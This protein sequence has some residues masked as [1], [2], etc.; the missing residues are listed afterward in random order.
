MDK[1]FT[2]QM[3]EEDSRSYLREWH[4]AVGRSLDWAE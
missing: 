4:K 2:P 1:V 3:R